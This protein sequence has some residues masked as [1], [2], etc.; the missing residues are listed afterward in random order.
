MRELDLA[1]RTL[2]GPEHVIWTGA[3]L[4]AVW[5]EGPH[6]YEIDGRFVLV[7]AEGGTEQNHAVV[8]ARAEDVRGPYVGNPANPVLTHRH[9][10]RGADVVGVG[11][12]DLVQ[13]VD[14]SWWAVLLAMRPYGGYHYPLGR[15]TFLVPVTWEDGWP[16]FSAGEGRVPAVV[17][18]PFAGEWAPGVTQGFATGV[19][20]PGDPRWSGV[21]G[22]PGEVGRVVAGAEGDGD[23]DGDGGAWELP[24][25]PARLSDVAVPAFLGLRQQHRDLD[26]LVRLRADLAEG[27]EAGIAV[28]Q[29]EAHH[30]RLAVGPWHD[31]ERTVRLVQRA[32]EAG[33]RTLG[34]IELVVDAAAPVEVT[35]RARGAEAELLVGAGGSESESAAEAAGRVRV[36]VVDVTTLDSVSAGGFL[37]LW[38]GVYA[39]SNGR[40]TTSV[41]QVERFA[42]D[43]R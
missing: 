13:A 5:A 16:V 8:V 24:V 34:E 17:E 35:L 21:R 42:Y 26:L 2:V 7:A 43:P 40:P 38:L 33:E 1:T 32:G 29:S 20:E 39:T 18:V 37:G 27:E 41:V 23:G 4:G 31:G 36:G 6:L 3:L 19:V 9:L 14:G 12:A 28:R 10:G 11:H 22:L 15:E 30:A 25:R